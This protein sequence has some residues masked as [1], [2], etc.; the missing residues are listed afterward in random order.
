M[1][2]SARLKA[3]QTRATEMK[4]KK[5]AAELI[6]VAALEGIVSEFFGLFRRETMALVPRLITALH[7]PPQQADTV[8]DAVYGTLNA[9]A[10]ATN[11]LAGTNLVF[12]DNS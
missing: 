7:L 6:E 11:P 10:K 5:Q 1:Q 9:I 4:L 12:E 2:A 3:A 8:R